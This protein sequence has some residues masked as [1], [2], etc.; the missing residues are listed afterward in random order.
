MSAG[1]LVD[2]SDLFDDIQSVGGAECDTG[3]AAETQIR[4]N[5]EHM[6]GALGHEA[7]RGWDDFKVHPYPL[8]SIRTSQLDDDSRKLREDAS[9]AEYP[10]HRSARPQ[11]RDSDILI[12]KQQVWITYPSSNGNQGVPPV[13]IL[14]DIT[15]PDEIHGPLRAGQDDILSG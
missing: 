1:L 13:D 11:D 9:T 7:M 14:M 5:L 15:T 10:T 2:D 3:S 12:P 4:V 6:P 8:V